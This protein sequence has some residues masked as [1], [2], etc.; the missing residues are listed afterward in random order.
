MRL[1]S[2]CLLF[3]LSCLSYS[4][5]QVEAKTSQIIDRVRKVQFA[6]A[7]IPDLPHIEVNFRETYSTVIL[8]ETVVTVDKISPRQIEQ[9]IQQGRYRLLYEIKDGVIIFSRP[10]DLSPLLHE[11]KEVKEYIQYNIAL[12]EYIEFLP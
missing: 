9:Y 8:V 11:G 10:S 1:F 6:K 3:F 7:N 12:P 4:S 2:L 5:A